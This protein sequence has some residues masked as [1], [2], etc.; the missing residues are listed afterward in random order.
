MFR[1]SGQYRS[2]LAFFLLLDI[3]IVNVAFFGA[4][5][6]RFD[7]RYTLVP[8]LLTQHMMHWA[9]VFT[10][11]AIAIF[12]LFKMYRS[13]WA[14]VG[15]Q[16]F[17]FGFFACLLFIIFQ[18]VI[19]RFTFTGIWIPRAFFLI[20][21]FL[22]FLG[23]MIER[24]S[25]RLMLH[26]GN[27]LVRNTE[28]GDFIP[29]LIIG[30]GEA[31][32]TLIREMNVSDKIRNKVVALI[33]DNKDKR[34]RYLEGVKIFGDRTDIVRVVEQL[35]IREIIL[36]LPS[37][38]RK[39]QR[40]ILEYCKLT[41]ASLKIV[42][43]IY[44]I[45]TGEVSVSKLRDVAIDDLLG[46]E[47][48]RVNSYEISEYIQNKTVLVTGGGGTIGSELCR[49]IARFKPKKLIIFDIFENNAYNI[50]MELN[51]HVPDLDLEVLIGSVR[52]LERLRWVF[53]RYRPEIVY[54]AAA[55]KHVPL[56]EVSPNE[57]IKN[58][59]F[60]TLNVARVCDEYHVHR[61]VLISTDKAVNPTNVMGATKRMCEMIFQS[62]DARS[63]TDFVAVRF[64]NVL[65]SS[66][67][68]IPLFKKQ[69]SEGGPVTV[70]HP[71]IVR[72][73]MTIPEAVSLVLQAGSYAKGGEIFI[74]DMG[75]PVRILDMAKNLIRLSGLK[76]GED[77]EIKIVGLRPGEKLYE[78][79]LMDEEGLQR[80]SNQHIKIGH[81]ID[82]DIEAFY[83]KLPELYA[84]SYQETD[85]IRDYIADIVSTF[86]VSINGVPEDYSKYQEEHAR[87]AKNDK[88]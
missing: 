72:F 71:D 44:Q 43:G 4:M 48:I 10:V 20:E 8:Y 42:P 39:E 78:E 50:Q 25:Y 41:D 47:P 67:S 58:N 22:L 32:R 17:I 37:A 51:A 33:D 3:L 63:E 75:E 45:I 16:E 85:A 21:F 23:V 11:L 52:N 55:H 19:M 56:M 73:F 49:Q 12:A 76:L 65:G 79:V 57:A 70:T 28:E 13:I 15:L 5:W 53:D 88:E 36:A 68:V 60:G 26:V 83:A 54:H 59:V 7:F 38:P 62:F 40:E 30:A 27:R 9:P 74:L 80:T 18:Y 34:G 86:K 87:E 29:T 77:I 64:G 2:K 66:G 82:F 6:I 14:Y 24:F 46:R 61:A 1:Q 84:A 31:G 69:I 35:G 81:P